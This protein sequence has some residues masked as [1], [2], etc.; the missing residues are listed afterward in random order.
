INIT[1]PKANRCL[2]ATG[3]GARRRGWGAK[4][5][6]NECEGRA[7]GADASGSRLDWQGGPFS[8]QPASRDHFL[9]YKQN[10]PSPRPLP[11]PRGGVITGPD[12]SRHHNMIA[13]GMS[14]RSCRAAGGLRRPSESRAFLASRHLHQSSES[15]D[16]LEPP[17]VSVDGLLWHPYAVESSLDYN[18]IEQ[19]TRAEAASGPDGDDNAATGPD[20]SRRHMIAS[21]MSRCSCRAAGGLRQ[22]SES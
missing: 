12:R 14:R 21:A 5:V 13:S 6:G 7:K 4:V 11:G 10:T 17:R 16:W 1:L 20:R 8:Y 22:P 9:P 18:M 3:Y 2:I 15:E 19:T